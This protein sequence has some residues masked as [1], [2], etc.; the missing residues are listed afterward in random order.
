[1]LGGNVGVRRSE[2]SSASVRPT[3]VASTV[4]C[5]RRED[6]SG[7]GGTGRGRVGGAAPRAAASASSEGDGVLQER[8]RVPLQQPRA[9]G[10]GRRLLHHG[11][12]PLPGD[13]GAGRAE[14]QVPGPRRS[15]ARHRRDL[16][17]GGA[18]VR[19]PAAATTFGRDDRGRRG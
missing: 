1:M 2:G 16:A 17:A 6:G 13:R 3:G 10:D 15:P 11:R 9:R 12:I 5:G 19:P 8:G 4:A 14:H 18:A 7:D